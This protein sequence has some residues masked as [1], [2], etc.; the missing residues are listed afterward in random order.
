MNLRELARLAG[1]SVSTVSKA[2]ND[3]DDVSE[4]TKEFIFDIAKIYCCF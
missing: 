1:V 3:A 2:F 4:K